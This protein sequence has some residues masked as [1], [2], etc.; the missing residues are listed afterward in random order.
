MHMIESEREG[1]RVS[2][3]E[4]ERD[5]FEDLCCKFCIIHISSHEC[6]YMTVFSG[7]LKRR[8][9]EM[10][11]CLRMSSFIYFYHYSLL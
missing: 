7:C 4:L 1:E 2:E 5:I 9:F 3:T 6:A 8:Y 11:I 10:D